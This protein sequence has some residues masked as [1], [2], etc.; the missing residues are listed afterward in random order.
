MFCILIFSKMEDLLDDNGVAY[1]RVILQAAYI[2]S[3]S[4]TFRVD[5]EGGDQMDNITQFTTF[6]GDQE[7]FFSFG[8]YIV[9]EGGRG[10]LDVTASG[11][12]VQHSE[13]VAL[14]TTSYSSP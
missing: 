14:F 2:A 12:V 1:S 5:L 9:M 13:D 10:S 6:L 3:V 8:D 11:N 7:A 4:L